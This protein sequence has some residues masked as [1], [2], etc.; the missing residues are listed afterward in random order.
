M[1]WKFWK[2]K[3]EEKRN[4]NAA[5]VGRLV[6]SWLATNQTSDEIIKADL[7]TLRAR[8]RELVRNNEYAKRFMTMLKTNVVGSRGVILQARSKDP[9][10]QPDKLA[11]DAIESVWS[12]WG[13]KC[14]VT[15]KLSWREAQVLFIQTMAEDGE[16]LV[17]KVGRGPYRFQLQFIDPVLLD[18]NY[19]KRLQRGY[20]RMGIEFNDWDEPIAYHIRSLA[21]SSDSYA[22]NGNDYI[23]IAAK[24]IIHSFLPERIGQKRGVPWM[25]PA[26]LRMNMLDGYA[27][28]ALV[29]ARVGAAKMG[30]IATPTGDEYTGDDKDASGNII[31]EAEAGTFE[32]VASGTELLAFDPQYPHGEFKD[33]MKTYLRGIAAAFGVSYN[34]LSNDLEGVNFSSIRTGVL[35]DREVWKNIQTMLIE[36]FCEPIFEEWLPVQLLLGTIRVPSKA[37]GTAPLNPAKIDKFKAVS[38]QPKRWAWVDPMKDML[39]AVAGIENRI[40]SVS[41]VIRERGDDPEEVWQEIAKEQERM[42]ALG[43]EQT[44]QTGMKSLIGVITNEEQ[45]TLP[46]A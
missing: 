42:K 38:W 43:I 3:K 40:T 36:K 9:D 5:Q 8:S 35:E 45:T 25:A 34:T 17:R 26:M 28:A 20:I 21:K 39:T 32:Q 15:G 23:R 10:G 22:Y 24:D 37:T 11:N 46:N 14:D 4:Y 18:I 7:N 33:T 16:V 1:N 2:K 19:N 31:T 30:F 29:A 12:A 44:V 13:K 41:A 27:E 6:S